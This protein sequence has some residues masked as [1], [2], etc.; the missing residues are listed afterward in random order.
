LCKALAQKLSIRLLE[1]RP[2]PFTRFRF[3]EVNAHA[4]FSKWFSESGKL[5]QKLFEGIKEQLDDDRSL[6]Y[7]VMIDEVESLAS[8]RAHGGNDPQDAVRVSWSAAQATIA[9]RRMQHSQPLC[10]L[11]LLSCLSCLPQAGNAVLTQLDRLKRYPNVLVLCTSNLTEMIDEAFTD[12][13]VNTSH[14]RAS[15][16]AGLERLS[17]LSCP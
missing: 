17:H 11:L 10:R 2:A 6:F 14:T 12:R 4:L 8:S 13:F 15:C 5:V 7:F 3:M 16:Q 1:L 9:T